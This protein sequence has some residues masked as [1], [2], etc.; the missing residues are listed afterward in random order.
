MES[1]DHMKTGRDLKS[2]KSRGKL[3]PISPMKK[4]I[5]AFGALL[6]TTTN[7]LLAQSNVEVKTV[8]LNANGK[9][10]SSRLVTSNFDSST[11]ESRL[12]FVK[13]VCDGDETRGYN[14][15]SFT[16]RDIIYNFEH[17]HFDR[18]FN[19][20]K[21]EYRADQRAAE[22]HNEVSG[23]WEGLHPQFLLRLCAGGQC[24]RAAG[25]ASSNMP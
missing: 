16:A 3:K 17:L 13:T 2:Q 22:R 8:D 6:L 24:Q 19:F 14:S 5:V 20:K 9:T 23:E 10:K 4:N 11:G 12:T 21:L 1:S 25:W 7:L 18:D 15:K